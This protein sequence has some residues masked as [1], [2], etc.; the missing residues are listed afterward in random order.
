[1]HPVSL[2]DVL[3]A[4]DL[5]R[6]DPHLASFS[7]TDWKKIGE[8]VAGVASQ[9]PTLG[10]VH[11]GLTDGI[12]IGEGHEPLS[13][14]PGALLARVD[15]YAERLRREMPGPSWKRSDVV[16][17]LLAKALDEAEPAR[18]GKR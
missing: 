11:L 17:L 18:K 13:R 3:D 16:R 15:A 2:F 1:M 10:A 7:M 4:W 8:A 5:L 6:E 9:E 14:I 12:A